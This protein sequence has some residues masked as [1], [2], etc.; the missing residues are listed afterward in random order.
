M[1]VSFRFKTLKKFL[2]PFLIGLFAY[3]G[4]N[5]FNIMQVHAYSNSNTFYRYQYDEINWDEYFST[6]G[7]YS[8]Q[9]I[10][11]IT[12]IDSS[13]YWVD[14][15]ILRTYN[16]STQMNNYILQLY[17]IPKERESI[18]VSNYGYNY[19]G[20]YYISYNYIP[21]YSHLVQWNGQLNSLITDSQF[22]LYYSKYYDCLTNNICDSN[23]FATTT[24][25]PSYRIDN[26]G[27]I[28]NNSSYNINFKDYL[29]D[30]TTDTRFLPYYTNI[31]INWNGIPNNT[32]TSQFYKKISINGVGVSTNDN[33]KHY[34]D[35][36]DCSISN[37]SS[38]FTEYLD[39]FPYV[40]ANTNSFTNYVLNMSFFPYDIEG[41]TDNFDYTISYYGRKNNSNYYTYDK[42]TC[43]S[44]NN[45]NI[46]TAY[47]LIISDITCTDNLS[48]YDKFFITIKPNYIHY[49]FDK[50]I[51]TFTLDSTSGK[52]IFDSLINN[53]LID[54]FT[55]NNN[56]FVLSSRITNR[57]IK[58]YFLTD[59][60]KLGFDY[61]SNSDESLDLYISGFLYNELP[62][63]KEIT[64]GNT[65]NRNLYVYAFS[66]NV[67]VNS[68]LNFRTMVS[69]ID[70]D[71]LTYY[72]SNGNITTNSI[73]VDYNNV[74]SSNK[75]DLTSV[76]NTINNFID[77]INEDLLNMHSILDNI[78]SNIPAF[79]QTF[80]FI[81]YTLFLVYLLFRFI[82][83]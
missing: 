30:N 50:T 71:E 63:P 81:I 75:Y 39:E 15:Y 17:L 26:F 59:Y 35:F 22:E 37:G 62:I 40:Y 76:F 29:F 48:N 6:E 16:P 64:Y 66:N 80:I 77:S 70:N 46:S 1:G 18:L 11:D 32:T 68:F 42:L 9:D 67:E 36:Y 43:S 56:S 74:D 51:S 57:D 55:L 12:Q 41:Y 24:D 72:D 73:N 5:G 61:I 25:K 58:S 54:N 31:P 52:A 23:Y 49:D 82:R 45:S 4:F 21:N 14:S 83:K 28:S 10:L 69:F 53:D 79:I 7:E 60:D 47:E 65:S 27:T 3:F 38:S 20:N 34:C 33:F 44:T 2:F 78:Y 8:F 19:N 13:Y